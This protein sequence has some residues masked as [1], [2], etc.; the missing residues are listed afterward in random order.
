MT[1]TRTKSTK[2][3][4]QSAICQEITRLL[5]FLL[6]KECRYSWKEIQSYSKPR[7][8]K[9]HHNSRATRAACLSGPS[10]VKKL[11]TTAN[12]STEGSSTASRPFPSTRGT[13]TEHRRAKSRILTLRAIRTAHSRTNSTRPS[14]ST[15]CSSSSCPNSNSSIG[16]SKPSSTIKAMFNSHQAKDFSL[17]TMRT[18]THPIRCRTLSFATQRQ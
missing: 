14:N 16:N 4:C 2:N 9:D 17:T 13:R 18:S 6:L 15:R 12:D 8:D 5:L 1:F 3:R 7:M 11:S 10:V